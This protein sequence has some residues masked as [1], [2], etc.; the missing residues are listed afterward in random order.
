MHMISTFFQE[1]EEIWLKN[2]TNIYFSPDSEKYFLFNNFFQTIQFRVMGY[3]NTFCLVHTSYAR[4]SCNRAGRFIV[5]LF[6]GDSASP[7][8]ISAAATLLSPF[9]RETLDYFKI[10]VIVRTPRKIFLFC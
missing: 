4:I 6:V 2:A 5:Y 8:R 1:E 3:S 9:S 10:Q 7:K